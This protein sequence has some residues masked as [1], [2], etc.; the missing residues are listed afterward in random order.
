[1]TIIVLDILPA[2]TTYRSN[3]SQ[4][5]I[6]TIES[7]MIRPPSLFT[8]FIKFDFRQINIPSPGQLPSYPYTAGDLLIRGSQYLKYITMGDSYEEK[9]GTSGTLPV[10]TIN[11]TPESSITHTQTKQWFEPREIALYKKRPTSLY[12]RNNPR[13]RSSFHSYS[14]WLLH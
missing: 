10:K 14:R 5:T 9:F 1:M 12:F 13:E 7:R 6:N 8:W 3:T 2:W 4:N 11:L